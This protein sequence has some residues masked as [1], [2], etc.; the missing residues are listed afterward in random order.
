M[1]ALKIIVVILALLFAF[2]AY[3]FHSDAP[4]TTHEVLRDDEAEQIQRSVDNFLRVVEQNKTSYVARGAHS[5]G[6]ACVKAWFEVDKDLRPE[7]QHGVFSLPGQRYRSWVRFSN[8][9]SSVAGNHDAD[10]DARG[11]AIKL[12]GL[13]ALDLKS[14]GPARD[15]QDFLMHDS[16]VFFTAN[17]EDYNRFVESKN[18]ILYFLSDPNPFKWRLRELMHGLATLK[19]PPPSP[20]WN[21]YFSN[22]AYRLGP[23]N[24]KFSTRSC[25][26]PGELPER[27]TT[28]PD[29]L[30]KTLATELQGSAACFYFMVQLQ[31][32]D[33]YMPIEDPSI[34][35]RETDS[36]FV[37]V[38]TI[39]IPQQT[40]DTPEQQAFC[41]NL[42]FSPWHNL[43]EHQPVGQ[44]NR[45]RKAVYAASSRYRHD[46]NHTQVPENIDW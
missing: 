17:I 8:G 16:P 34:E 9:A 10:K 42:S 32:A 20:L 3:H 38:A 31:D 14:Q 28:D 15:T 29:F 39:N 45:I 44:L 21:R 12:F 37:R 6:H 40:F 46:E 2:I 5:K 41:E 18:K 22:T 33:K 24:I 13:K 35:W 11:M 4:V 25:T 26:A 43:P 7:L 27:D 30:R 1:R 19:P 23:H 36:P